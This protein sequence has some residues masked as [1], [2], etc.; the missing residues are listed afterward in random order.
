[1]QYEKIALWC[2]LK[3]NTA[4]GFSLCCIHLSP[5]PLCYFFPYYTRGGALTYIAL[6]ETKYSTCFTSCYIC[7]LST[8]ACYIFCIALT[9]LFCLILSY[10]CTYTLH[11]PSMLHTTLHYT[12]YTLHYTY[13]THMYTLTISVPNS[14]NCITCTVSLSQI[15]CI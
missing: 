8:L 4:L 10:T 3:P 6:L 5:M 9:A 1:M 15:Y 12:T 11:T 14:T 2:A 7:F 13:T